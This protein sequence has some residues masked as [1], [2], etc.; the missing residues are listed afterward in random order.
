MLGNEHHAYWDN[1]YTKEMNEVLQAIADGNNDDPMDKLFV[2]FGKMSMV[3]TAHIVQSA[4]LNLSHDS[5]ILDVGC[6]NGL[7]CEVLHA[8]GFTNIL[9]S[10]YS[11]EA[12]KLSNE[13]Q[14][15]YRKQ[16]PES[17]SWGTRYMCDDLL[18]TSL[19][20]ESFHLIHDSGTVNMNLFRL[21]IAYVL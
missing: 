16:K 4:D 18:N 17:Q 7:F 13:V 1:S 14:S 6:G 20:S 2:W 10:D 19:E 21:K 3:Y 5:A 8:L 9:G 11:S 12:I 15:Y